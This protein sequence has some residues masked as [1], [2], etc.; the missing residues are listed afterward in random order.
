MPPG[1][2]LI[3]KFNAVIARIETSA[4]P[5]DDELREPSVLP[6]DLF[7][8]TGTVQ[9][10]ESTEIKVKVQMLDEDFERLRQV[11]NG[12]SPVSFMDL[13]THERQLKAAGLIAPD[14]QP[15]LGKQDRL[16]RVET[17]GGETMLVVSSSPGLYL[18]ELRPRGWGLGRRPRRNLFFLHFRSRDIG[19]SR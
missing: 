15:L 14:G 4:I 2:R 18:H 5:Y 9:R 3:F 6:Y 13:T 16:A 1:N 8:S 17:L 10:V 12:D 7:D 11:S 19:A